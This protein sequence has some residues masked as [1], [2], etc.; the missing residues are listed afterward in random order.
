MLFVAEEAPPGALT[1]SP[2]EGFVEDLQAELWTG[3][4]WRHLPPSR[5]CCSPADTHR[6]CTTVLP[7]PL[8]FC[9]LSTWARR[10]RKDFLESG[11]SR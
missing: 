1:K 4:I 3:N 9:H 6:Q 5:A 10:C 2:H 11:V 8:S 7:S